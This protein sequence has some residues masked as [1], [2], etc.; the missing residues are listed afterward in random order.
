MTVTRPMT[1]EQ[2]SAYELTWQ[3]HPFAFRSSA[4]AECRVVRAVNGAQMSSQ[5][6][7]GFT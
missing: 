1:C 5:K 3:H 6:I 2:S 4:F 7:D